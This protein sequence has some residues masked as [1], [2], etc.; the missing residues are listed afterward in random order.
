MEADTSAKAW[1][2]HDFVDDEFAVAALPR[3]PRAVH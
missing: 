1:S 3:P 2:N